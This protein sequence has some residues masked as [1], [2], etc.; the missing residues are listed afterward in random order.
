M[1][2][3]GTPLGDAAV[4]LLI[5]LLIGLERQRAQRPDEPLFAG[6][7]TFP[8]LA[9]AGYLGAFAQERGA[10]WVLPALIVGLAALVV[11][12]YLRTSSTHA[13]ATTEVA[14]LVTPLLG[15]LLAWDEAPLAVALGLVVTLL[16][17]LKERLHALA[18]AV[19]ETEIVAI[20]KFAIVAAVVLPLLPAEPL[21]PYGAIVPRHVGFVV[22]VLSGLSLAGYLLVRLV[23]G[24]AGWA[25]AGL[26]GGLV[27]STAVTLSFSGQARR[28]PELGAPLRAGIALAC[29]V[30]YARSWLLVTLFDA[31]LGR[32]LLPALGLLFV[33]GAAFAAW[34]L[35]GQARRG[36][37]EHGLTLGNPVE[38]GRALGL[39]LLFAVILLGARA[40]QAELGGQGLL[41][42]AFLGG[43]TDVDSIALAVVRLAQH[44]SV[45]AGAAAQ[46]FL[47]A[48]L[49]NLLLKAGLVMGIGGRA[50]ARGLLPFFAALGATTAALLAWG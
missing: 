37:G 2:G 15:A 13:G 11:A 46:A 42:V 47:L 30:L 40:A 20:L 35:R 4:A 45:T 19:S 33:V 39:G 26:L 41:G 7:R 24:G 44:G 5:G 31:G 6:I 48:T 23:G 21:G 38:L 34:F 43:L 22:L 10:P 25:L 36:A 8:L 29:T 17:T 12:A 28:T 9:L 27:S 18:G 1:P 32:R 49:A 14:A 3:L 50:L 16:L